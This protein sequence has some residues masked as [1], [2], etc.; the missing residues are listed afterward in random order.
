LIELREFFNIE[1]NFQ[2]NLPDFV[3]YNIYIYII[4][5]SRNMII[6]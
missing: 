1:N 5:Q 2:I 4:I 3:I 6:L